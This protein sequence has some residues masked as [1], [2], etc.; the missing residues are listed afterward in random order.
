[1]SLLTTTLPLSRNRDF[2]I[3]NLVSQGIRDFLGHL[4]EKVVAGQLLDV[5]G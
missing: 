4:L 1:V 3:V 2:Y 5:A